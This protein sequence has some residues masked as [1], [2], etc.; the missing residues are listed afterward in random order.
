MGLSVITFTGYLWEDLL[1]SGRE[2]WLR[3]IEASDIIV[4]G[5]FIQ[6]LRDLDLRF[7][8]SANQRLIDVRRSL[9]AGRTIA[10]P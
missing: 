10:L 9:V 1:S 7:R 3:L 4:D 2:D 5:P 6:A 8:G